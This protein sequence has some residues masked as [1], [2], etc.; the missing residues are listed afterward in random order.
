[1]EQ[2]LVVQLGSQFRPAVALGRQR[3]PVIGTRRAGDKLALD[4]TLEEALLVIVEQLLA[5][6]AVSQGREA[7]AGNAGDDIDG[8]EQ[9]KLGAFLAIVATEEPNAAEAAARVPPPE[10]ARITR[11]SWLFVLTAWRVSKRYPARGSVCV[12][13][14]LTGRI[15]VA[16]PPRNT[17]ATSA[18]QYGNR[19]RIMISPITCPSTSGY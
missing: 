12:I 4:V 19:K 1:V 10:N 8:V 15:A 17:T 6:Q 13:G 14:G 16:Q 9:A 11:L 18:S 7:A 5:I 3:S 2:D